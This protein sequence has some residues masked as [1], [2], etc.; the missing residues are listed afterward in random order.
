VFLVA[1]AEPAARCTIIG[2]LTDLFGEV[3]QSIRVCVES[4][5]RVW[6]ENTEG[7]LA[8]NPEAVGHAPSQQIVFPNADGLWQ[9]QLAQ[10][11]IARVTIAPLNYDWAF[12]VPAVEGPVNIRDTTLLR[13]GDRYNVYPEQVGL[14]AQLVRS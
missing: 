3:D 14:A 5:G 8:Q 4:Y 10:R 7:V 9:V 6:A 2:Y 12:E 1:P 11:S 13:Q